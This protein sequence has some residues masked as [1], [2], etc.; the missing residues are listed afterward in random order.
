[1]S[2]TREEIMRVAKELDEALEMRNIDRIVEYFADDCQIELLGLT[3]TGKVGVRKWLNWIFQNVAEIVLEPVTIM[4]E[5]DTF[6]EE[7]RVEGTL[8]DGAKVESKQSEVLVY[9]N[10][11]VKQLRLYFDRLDFAK[12]VARGF[13]S[14]TVVNKLIKESLKG[15]L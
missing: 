14:R 9:E 4:V 13:V 12:S 6:F 7:F 15:L 5:D 10:C 1:M 2:Q 8:H 11:L 3:L